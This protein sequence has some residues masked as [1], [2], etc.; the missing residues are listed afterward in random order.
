M[1]G[2]IMLGSSLGVEKAQPGMSMSMRKS[3]E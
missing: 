2:S 1:R 3:M